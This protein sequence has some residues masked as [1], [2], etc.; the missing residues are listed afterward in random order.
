[1]EKLQILE[2]QKE[3]EEFKGLQKVP[4]NANREWFYY[5]GLKN[6]TAVRD[7]NNQK[8]A[9]TIDGD[10]S[11]FDKMKQEIFVDYGDM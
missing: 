7:K 1:M 3:E 8:F 2:N 5:Q 11:A 10:Q 6:M 9:Q 4:D